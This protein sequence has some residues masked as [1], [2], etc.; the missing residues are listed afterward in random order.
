MDVPEPDIYVFD[1]GVPWK[2]IDPTHVRLV[3]EIADNSRGYDLGRKAA[4][5]A[6]YG[7]GEYWVVDVQA[8][9]T[10]VLRGVEDGAYHEIAAVAFDQALRP[11]RVPGVELV[12]ADVPGL[13][14]D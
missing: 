9:V 6:Q 14:L 1:A 11:Q 2:P 12:I 5:Y 3:V 7:I 8:R 10:H 13:K 4:K